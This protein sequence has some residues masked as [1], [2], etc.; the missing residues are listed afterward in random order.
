M[1]VA[2]PDEIL[3]F[4]FNELSPKD[5]FRK[6]PDLD[7]RI[8]ARFGE[9]YESVRHQIPDDWLTTPEGYLAAVI[10]FDQFPRNMFRD[11]PRAFATDAMALALSKRAIAEGLDAKLD[12]DKRAFLYM[13][14]QH[15][16]DGADQ[17]RCVELFAAL[18][19]PVELDFANRHKAI[20][21]R[22][23]RFPHR[24]AILGR[25]STE[26]EIAFLLEPGSSF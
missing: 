4:W 18:G 3:H 5:W 7:N 20:I 13:P 1:S 14:F 24:N 21:D 6:D 23:G 10:V 19:K 8:A 25:T 9:T 17:A 12:V 15:A 26:E 2:S 16:E 22:F 11:D